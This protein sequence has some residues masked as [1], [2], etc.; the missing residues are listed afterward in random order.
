[1]WCESK[2]E[3]QIS[4]KLGLNGMD[5]KRLLI[6][7]ARGFLGM[8]AVKAAMDTFE[9][10]R[11]DRSGT[12]QPESVEIDVAD[13]SSVNRAFRQARPDF[14]LLL[15][16]MSDID[17]CERLPE[18]AFAVNARGAETVA[19]ACA[20]TGARLLFTSSAAVFDG[21][22]HGY[23]EEDAVGP[24]SVYGKTKAWAENAVKA[25]TPS[26]I[27]VRF[28]LVLGFARK[29]GTHA[30]LDTVIERWK[31]GEPVSFS[32]REVRNPIEATSLSKIMIGMLADHHVSGLYHVG[33]SDSIS[34]YELGK[35]L[36]ARAG[37]S[38]DLVRPQHDPV[39]GR[40]PRGEDHF[41]LTEKV[42][43]VCNL[44]V[45]S[46]DQVIERCFL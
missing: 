44:E 24:L 22:K 28:A 43:R 31:V 18:Q 12:G 3:W 5:R 8:H 13:A 38:A 34:R 33:S 32:T 23:S 36:A 42:H 6:I 14:V 40:A 19:N 15:A 10:I 16:A 39:P 37:V 25:L 2:K 1:V 27:I 26:A 35:R 7:G 20:R 29:S 41:L 11:G 4:L 30:M 45:P 21:R 9:V 46:S 17:R